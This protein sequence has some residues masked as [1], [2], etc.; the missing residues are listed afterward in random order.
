M[1]G[2]LTFELFLICLFS[3]FYLFDQ[4]S[5]SVYSGRLHLVSDLLQ[6]LFKEAYSLQK[7]LMELLDMVC[8]DPGVDENDDIL[9]MVLGE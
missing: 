5:E 8:M 3:H 9:N 1:K 2:N 7:Q 6:A 4:N